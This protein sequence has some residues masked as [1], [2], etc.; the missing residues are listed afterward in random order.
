[1]P[2]IF[3]SRAR[4]RSLVSTTRTRLSRQIVVPIVSVTRP[5]R[6]SPTNPVPFR[7]GAAR[8]R[9]GRLRPE[10]S[11]LTMVVFDPVSKINTAGLPLTS[12]LTRSA[13]KRALRSMGSTT[14]RF[15]S[16]GEPWGNGRCAAPPLASAQIASTLAARRTPNRALLESFCHIPVRSQPQ[17]LT[18]PSSFSPTR[19]LLASCRGRFALAPFPEHEFGYHRHK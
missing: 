2:S 10:I 3:R 4:E 17:V 11:G 9:L 18:H 5:Q 6:P 19:L 12:R 15:P 7:G 16:R 13:R 14:R 8:G 1:M